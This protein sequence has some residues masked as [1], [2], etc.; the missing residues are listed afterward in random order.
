MTSKSAPV[1]FKSRSNKKPSQKKGIFKHMVFKTYVKL[2]LPI[3]IQQATEFGVTEQVV[4]DAVTKI[5]KML[6]ELDT[7]TFILAWHP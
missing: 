1:Y 5:W 7:A 3:A 6:S 4:L 2:T